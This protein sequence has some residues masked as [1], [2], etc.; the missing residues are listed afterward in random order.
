MLEFRI[1]S[2]ALLNT[3]D[4]LAYSQRLYKLLLPRTAKDS[5][6]SLFNTWLPQYL[7]KAL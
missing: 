3:Q 5:I 4:A 1:L 7:I 6:F 2:D